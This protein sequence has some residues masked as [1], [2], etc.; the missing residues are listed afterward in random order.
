[1]ITQEVKIKG[2]TYQVSS[3]TQQGIDNAI[4]MLK[5]SLKEIKKQDKEEDNGIY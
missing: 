1:M 2:I 5:K 4:I 3:S